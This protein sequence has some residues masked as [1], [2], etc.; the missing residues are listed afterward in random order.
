MVAG[1]VEAFL[2]QP[3]VDRMLVVSFDVH[4]GHHLKTH[5]VVACA[6]LTNV[7]GGARLLLAKLVAREAQDDQALVF[8]LVVQFL[9]WPVLRG[10]TATRGGVDNHDAFA[11]QVAEGVRVAFQGFCGQVVKRGHGGSGLVP[12]VGVESLPCHESGPSK[13]DHRGEGKGCCHVHGRGNAVR[14]SIVQ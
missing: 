3:C 8:V 9:E 1:A 12:N 6:E 10:V 2:R 14:R 5:A 11:F 4:L 7:A 13:K